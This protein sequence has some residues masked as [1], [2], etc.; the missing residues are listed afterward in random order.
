[1]LDLTLKKRHELMDR[2]GQ[3]MYEDERDYYEYLE[4]HRE[5]SEEIK[6]LKDILG[7]EIMLDKRSDETEKLAINY[8]R[9]EG[10]P[11]VSFRLR[12]DGLNDGI[13]VR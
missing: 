5:R 7:K 13:G 12:D 1:M 10:K 2:L 4:L 3:L 6:K 8:Y 9:K 11:Y